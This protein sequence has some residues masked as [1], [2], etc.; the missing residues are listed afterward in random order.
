M[1]L[2][3][4]FQKFPVGENSNGTVRYTDWND[5]TKVRA[6]AAVAEGAVFPESTAQWEEYSETLKKTGDSIKVTEE[7]IIDR[8]RFVAELDR[9]LDTNVSLVIDQG[10]YDGDGVGQNLLGVYTTAPTYT[11]PASGITDANIFDLLRKTRSFISQGKRSKYMPNVAMMNVQDIDR[12]L[13]KKD[14]NNNY[15]RPDF[16]QISSEATNMYIVSGIL[17]I[18]TNTVTPNTMLVGDSRF[19]AIYEESG[20]D[21]LMG[22]DSDDFSRDLRTLKARKRLLMLVRTIDR[23]AWAKITDISAAL[24]LLA[25]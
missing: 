8:A 5:A 18:E 19:A 20:F 13:L 25:T 16:F 24:V 21:I 4:F 23:D 12:M 9:F 3:D 15:V 14:A 10:L 6:A 2:Y 1:V 7:S 11:P 22:M 17:I